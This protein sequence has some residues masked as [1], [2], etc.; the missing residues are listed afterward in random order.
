[1]PVEDRRL[2]D[3]VRGEGGHDE[4]LAVLHEGVVGGVGRHL[5]FAVPGRERTEKISIAMRR[6][7]GGDGCERF[8]GEEVDGC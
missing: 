1:M 2:A 7:R 5:E 3:D 4:E 6:W 8:K